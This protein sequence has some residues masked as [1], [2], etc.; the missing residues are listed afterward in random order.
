MASNGLGEIDAIN[1]HIKSS[2]KNADNADANVELT[3]AAHDAAKA[4]VELTKAAH[5]AAKAVCK[6]T[7]AAYIAAMKQDK[8]AKEDV[9]DAE[10]SLN[11]KVV[12]ISSDEE[13]NDDEGKSGSAEAPV[14]ASEEPEPVAQ[15]N[16]ANDGAENGSEKKR[17]AVPTEQSSGANKKA[18]SDV[19]IFQVKS[20]EVSGCCTPVLP[21]STAPMLRLGCTMMRHS[22]R[23]V[24][25][26][27]DRI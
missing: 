19:D 18:R 15:S 22:S 1:K 12:D 26:G 14:A 20:I 16:S 25:S 24:E 9:K 17:A 4:N 11:A 21:R 7:E 13:G 27:W 3:K 10:A 8:D 5:D 6:A 23:V 2:K